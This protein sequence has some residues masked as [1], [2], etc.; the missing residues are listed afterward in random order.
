[1][2]NAYCTVRMKQL[3][4]WAV[5]RLPLSAYAHASVDCHSAQCAVGS[6]VTGS[7]VALGQTVTALTTIRK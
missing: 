4:K 1:M 6:A 7:L 5:W 2:H 3:L